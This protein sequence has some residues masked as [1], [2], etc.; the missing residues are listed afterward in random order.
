VIRPLAGNRQIAGKTCLAF[1]FS[2]AMPKNA[3]VEGTAWLDAATGLPVECVSTPKPLPRAVH[4]M[5]TTVRYDGGFVSEVRVE[6]SGTL[7]FFKRR[8]SSVIT[9][10]GWF[11]MPG[12]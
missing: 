10:A 5:N 3:V 9:L 4:E 7:L 12:G 6:G 2:L 1:A 11:P 8:F